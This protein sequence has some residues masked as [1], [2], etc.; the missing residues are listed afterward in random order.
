MPQ[1]GLPEI[2]AGRIAPAK[3]GGALP[4][5]QD[6]DQG[7]KCGAG[8]RLAACRRKPSRLQGKCDLDFLRDVFLAMRD[9][10]R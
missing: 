4:D 5:L 3:S 1:S 6:A 10:R 2:H 9:G 7:W 8:Q